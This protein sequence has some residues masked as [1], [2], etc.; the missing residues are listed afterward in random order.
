MPSSP[1]NDLTAKKY[2]GD[3]QAAYLG[4]SLQSSIREN[5]AS[6]GITTT[7][8]IDALREKII[9][10]ALLCR[11]FIKDNEVI[12]EHFIATSEE[13]ILQSQGS[14]YIS[15][16]F[17]ADAL[18]LM[19]SFNGNLTLVCLPCEARI[20]HFL[21]EKDDQIDSKL[22]LVITL[23]CGHA[24]EKELTQL[25][26]RKLNPHNKPVQD[27]RYRSGHWR[28]NLKLTFKDGS[29]I[30][31]PFNYFSD[32][33][34][35]FLF[36]EAKCLQCG[37]QTGIYS[38]ISIGDVWSIKMKNNPIKHNAILV[39]T[40]AGAKAVARV[41][42]NGFAQIIPVPITEICAGQSRSLVLH[43][44]VNARA[45]LAPSFGLKIKPDSDLK[46]PLLEKFAARIVLYNFRLSHKDS[47]LETIQRIPRF[48]I[49]IYLYAFKG[50]QV[51]LKPKP[52]KQSIAIMGGSIWGNRGAESMLVT[53]IALLKEKYP[54]ADYKVF[55]IYPEK[56]RSLVDDPK[57]TVLSSSPK[58][59]ALIFFPFALLHWLFSRIGLKIWLPAQVR[60]LRDC[61]LMLDIG[62][63]TFAERGLV[64]LYNI[65]TLWPAM[66]LGVPVV[67]L[68]QA[69]GPFNAPINR[70]CAKI[71]LNRCQR[72]YPRGELSARFLQDLDIKTGSTSSI[73]A[74]IAFLYQPGFSLSVENEDK[75]KALS[76]R[77]ADF[78]KTGQTTIF[79]S[80]SSVVLKKIKSPYYEQMLLD[81][82][83][84]IDRKDYHYVFLPN[85]NRSESGKSQNNDILAIL[86][87]K[88]LAESQFSPDLFSRIEWIN[89]DLNTKGIR[90]LFQYANLVLTSRF[91]AMVSALSLGIPVYVI[92][93][94]HKYLE[95]LRMFGLDDYLIDFKDINSKVTALE[96]T[97]ILASQQAIKEKILRNQKSVIQLAKS[98]FDQIDIKFS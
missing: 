88:E 29:I 12:A 43:A 10:G 90:E 30:T 81:I 91:H 4:Y 36:T 93:W 53:T 64:L 51:M 44:G 66:L 87:I 80:P 77:L 27:F 58:S 9:D 37:D 72:I 39:R 3:Y 46:P 70:A 14:K 69:V 16:R 60:Q 13:E 94:S 47:S 8:L 57:I 7:I 17:T 83:T 73:A 74:D 31:K 18:P 15:T 20:L 48:L 82:I 32:Y 95:V 1:W 65:F 24:S 42:T 38:D 97:K 22:K 92:G 85:S 55:S 54:Q 67:K 26:L 23:F 50:L 5:A 78:K 56:D 63:I 45:Q 11:S 98:Q 84:G 52:A 79:I 62:G 25:V 35:L 68:S 33:Q 41:Q 19:R 28:G 2:L 59:L 75:V 96:I 6:G 76:S 86:K 89:W 21:R 34:N 49:K 40:E 71:F 61:S